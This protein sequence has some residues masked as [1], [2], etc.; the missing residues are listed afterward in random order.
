MAV[1]S[2]ATATNIKQF[3]CVPS[4]HFPLVNLNEN[5]EFQKKSYIIVIDKLLFLFY[6]LCMETQNKE[7]EVK[8]PH[9]DITG[10]L[11]FFEQLCKDLSFK[12]EHLCPLILADWIC[13]FQIAVSKANGNVQNA[14]VSYLASTKKTYDSLREIEKQIQESSKNE[15]NDDVDVV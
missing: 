15:E 5:S 6:I 1:C 13:M 3:L 14:F 2:E 11:Q 4:F 10:Q 8:Y 7:V 9:Y 12:W